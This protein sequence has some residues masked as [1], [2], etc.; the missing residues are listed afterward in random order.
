VCKDDSDLDSLL[1]VDTSAV[2]GLG[3][4]SSVNCGGRELADDDDDGLLD[5]LLAAPVG[6]PSGTDQG[7]SHLDFL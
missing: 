2:T 1:G 5:A 4:L 3:P 6:L 7:G